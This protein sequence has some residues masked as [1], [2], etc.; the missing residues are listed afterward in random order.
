MIM[1]ASP[2]LTVLEATKLEWGGID[3]EVSGDATALRDV[4]NAL[5][6]RWKLKGDYVPLYKA[7][8]VYT[9]LHGEFNSFSL[10]KTLPEQLK[11]DL[12]RRLRQLD[13]IGAITLVR[14]HWYVANKP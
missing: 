7:C 9:R 14:P 10:R 8:Q 2:H 13:V 1:S 11:P 3:V 6:E 4:R 5:Y 12:A